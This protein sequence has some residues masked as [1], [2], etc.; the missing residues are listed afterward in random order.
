VITVKKAA[1]AK[2][3][4]ILLSRA[5]LM[6]SL[7][8]GIYGSGFEFLPKYN[9]LRFKSVLSPIIP[10]AASVASFLRIPGPYPCFF[11]RFR[12]FELPGVFSDE[13]RLLSSKSST[14]SSG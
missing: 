12:L 8:V 2:L 6:L 14:S 11:K 13:F 4:K 1:I 7:R 10:V 3:S 5:S 9:F